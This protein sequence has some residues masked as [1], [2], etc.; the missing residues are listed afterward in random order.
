[1]RS[2]TK[3][4]INAKKKKTP[5]S[6]S[7]NDR[8]VSSEVA[9]QKIKQLMYQNQLAPGQKI[10]YQDLAKK[11]NLSIT[12]V[13]NA[14]GRLL[15]LKLVS[16]ELNRG[17]FVRTITENETV[18]LYKAREA[19]ETFVIPEVIKNLNSKKLDAIKSAYKEHVIEKS[20]YHRRL[21]LMRDLGLHLKIVE[22][23]GNSVIYDIVK[24]IF[25]RIYLGYRPEY[26]V[27]QR[28][29]SVVKEHRAILDAL[30][31]RDIEAAIETTKKHIR[32]GMD[33]VLT[34]IYTEEE[35]LEEYNY[36]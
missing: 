36:L 14:L 8:D 7:S 29:K 2:K 23:A 28:I 17:Y 13:V 5:A 26:L 24:G 9:F 16:Y 27:D 21:V 15:I 20:P 22:I 10:I 30:E 3:K 32:N 33:Y 18:E 1:M 11:L 4:N 6:L 34:S 35:I 31:R 12:P 25:E 19:L